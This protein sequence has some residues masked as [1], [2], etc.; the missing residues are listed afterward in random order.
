MSLW[1]FSRHSYGRPSPKSWCHCHIRLRNHDI[2]KFVIRMCGSE[3]LLLPET[4]GRDTVCWSQ[5]Q[6]L[7]FEKFNRETSKFQPLQKV[8]IN[9]KGHLLMAWFCCPGYSSCTLV[10]PVSCILNWQEIYNPITFLLS[11]WT[12]QNLAY[13]IG[14][15]K[16]HPQPPLCWPPA[17]GVRD[18]IKDGV[19]R[20]LGKRIL[21]GRIYRKHWWRIPKY[22][23]TSSSELSPSCGGLAG[24]W[25]YSN[26]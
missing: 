15:L 6:I 10:G 8:W 24:L 22:S 14:L 3:E 11:E 17:R 19:V 23:E 1:H 2:A 4:C 12:Y 21:T 25:H 26:V 18:T 16:S 9:Y 7:Y 20:S 5:Y 13:W